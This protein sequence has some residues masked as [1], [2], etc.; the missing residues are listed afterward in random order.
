MHSKD[1]V[2]RLLRLMTHFNI[3]LALGLVVWLA[4][5]SWQAVSGPWPAA[6]QAASLHTRAPGSAPLQSQRMQLVPVGDTTQPVCPP[7]PAVLTG[8]D[9]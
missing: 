9:L 2:M 3:G 5:A 8:D 1:P 6:D 4:W 7:P